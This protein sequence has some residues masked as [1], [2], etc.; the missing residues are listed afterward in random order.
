[1]KEGEWPPP[2][3]NV[4]VT[5]E[6]IPALEFEDSLAEMSASF[7]RVPAGQVSQEIERWLE[8]V[9]TVLGIDRATVGEINFSDGFLYTTHQWAGSG[10]R[11]T[12]DKLNANEALPWL[13]GKILAG[14]TVI[15]SDLKDAPP[16]AARD[17]EYARGVGCKSNLT[18]PLKIGGAVVGAVAYDAV[19]HTQH[20][21]A[22]T[23]QRLRLLAD[24]FGNAIERERSVSEMLRL[25]DAVRRSSHAANMGELTAS[26]AHE[27]NQPLGAILSNAQAA[28][29]FLAAKKP[30]LAEV[31]AAVEEIIHDNSRAV[32]TLRNVRTLFR[33]DQVE[34]RPLDP[35]EVMIEAARL[36]SMEAARK[37]IS[38]RLD[39]PPALPLINGN[40]TQLLEVLMNLAANSFDS[41]CED[42][43]G[44]RIVE[45][46]ARDCANGNLQIVVRDF[47]KGIDAEV[48]PRLFDA[49]FTTKAH[50]MGIGLRIART[51]AENHRGRLWAMPN[52]ERGAALVFELPVSADEQART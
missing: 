12:P 52:I 16:E 4:S 23:V 39:L 41:I 1:M 43:D 10:I 7:A 15:L 36:L 29:R 3:Q 19:T 9:V 37:G 20:W 47:G 48:F 25:A 45:L 51:I 28:R 5:A 8:Y 30:D 35:R 44:P 32:E 27:L 17:L 31:R 46:H 2:A 40:H 26:L 49:F 6:D 50:G 22:R 42:G 34:M 11:P 24:M 14:E 38:I 13:T 21:S 33:R 18:V